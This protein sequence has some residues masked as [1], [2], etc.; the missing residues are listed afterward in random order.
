[1]GTTPRRGPTT[2]GDWPRLIEIVQKPFHFFV[3]VALIVEGM[4]VASTATL[5]GHDKF[6]A[7]LVAAVLLVILLAVVVGI[8]VWAPKIFDLHDH[9]RIAASAAVKKCEECCYTISSLT[10]LEVLL[11]MRRGYSIDG[12]GF[13][14]TPTR[15]R[16][17]DCGDLFG[18]GIV[19]REGETRVLPRTRTLSQIVGPVLEDP[20]LVQQI[21]QIVTNKA[22]SGPPEALL[23]RPQAVP[24]KRLEDLNLPPSLAEPASRGRCCNCFRRNR[25]GRASS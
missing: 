9:S 13:I 14:M 1:M 20:G 12:V 17:R 6:S 16:I 23:K 2:R 3:L 8:A 25:A 21:T 22:M 15:Q 7:L 5:D 19:F 24:S 18:N 10:V 4:I 11:W